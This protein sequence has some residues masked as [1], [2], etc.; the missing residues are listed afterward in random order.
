M[1]KHVDGEMMRTTNNQ[2]IEPTKDQTPN[3]T[4]DY[5]SESTVHQA[6]DVTFDSL[7]IETAI[8]V[9]QTNIKAF[10]IFDHR[11]FFSSETY[12]IADGTHDGK[13]VTKYGLDFRK[14]T[15]YYYKHFYPET[16]YIRLD[17]WPPSLFLPFTKMMAGQHH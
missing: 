9:T 10:E 13:M 1:P 6:E 16:W 2:T 7:D 5:G 15:D 4:V 11:L 12:R 14:V 17:S 8:A 3:N